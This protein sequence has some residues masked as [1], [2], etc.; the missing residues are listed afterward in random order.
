MATCD[1]PSELVY[2]I[3]YPSLQRPGLRKDTPGPVLRAEDE[4]ATCRILRACKESKPVTYFTVSSHR[5][6]YDREVGGPAVGAVAFQALVLATLVVAPLFHTDPLPKRETVTML[7]LQP[8]QPR[9]AMPRS[10]ERPHLSLRRYLPRQAPSI[11]APLHKTQEATASVRRHNGRSG[12]RSPRRNGRR[13]SR[14]N[15]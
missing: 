4:A 13:T 12:R 9:L 1:H 5:G 10:F 6:I 14:R 3:A 8:P 15:V 2:R 11:P 7:Y